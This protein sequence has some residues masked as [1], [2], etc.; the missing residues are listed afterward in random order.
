MTVTSSI[1]P[2]RLLDLSTSLPRRMDKLVQSW[3]SPPRR[4]PQVSEMARNLDA[5]GRG[6]LHPP[7]RGEEASD[8]LTLHAITA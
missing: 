1:D 5:Q 4:S 8:E 3:G 6:V 2:A 7:A